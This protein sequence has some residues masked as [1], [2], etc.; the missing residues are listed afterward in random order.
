MHYPHW[1]TRSGA[2]C[3]LILTQLTLGA[4]AKDSTSPPANR[5]LALSFVGLE[6]LANGYHYEGWAIV[7][8]QPRTAGKSNVTP[9]GGLVTV[10]A[11]EALN[12]SLPTT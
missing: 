2:T 6:P 9:S 10:S 7:G 1:T 8:G 3:A 11:P 5:T 12:N 4:C